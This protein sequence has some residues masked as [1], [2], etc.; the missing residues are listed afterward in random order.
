VLLFNISIFSKSLNTLP[1]PPKTLKNRLIGKHRQTG[2][3]RQTTQ[4]QILHA[5]NKTH[6]WQTAV[7][8][9][10][11]TGYCQA[12]DSGRAKGAEPAFR[13]FFALI[14]KNPARKGAMPCPTS[15]PSNSAHCTT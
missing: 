5:P 10:I 12:R 7:V 14:T 8:F 4:Y 1:R 11:A 13:A 6:F 3:R 9:L 15:R 2:K